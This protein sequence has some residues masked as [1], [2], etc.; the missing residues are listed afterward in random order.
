MLEV[1]CTNITPDIVFHHSG[2]K[3]RF[4]DYVVQD[5]ETKHG[6]RADHV[7]ED[8]IDKK[9]KDPKANIPEDE[10]KKL[11]EYRLHAGGM[12]QEELQAVFKE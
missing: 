8:F 4:L 3:E 11:E 12:N 5:L 2:H 7:L 9:L 6:M 1:T 10:K